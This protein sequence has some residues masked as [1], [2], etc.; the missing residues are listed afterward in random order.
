MELF[1]VFFFPE[2]YIEGIEEFHGQR[3]LGRII[4]RQPSESSA[5]TISE[6]VNIAF[7]FSQRTP[8]VLNSPISLRKF[9]SS[10]NLT[11]HQLP[12]H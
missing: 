6:K 3:C 5:V 1:K 9:S 8:F 11:G 12:L 7:S 4:S 2:N 10:H